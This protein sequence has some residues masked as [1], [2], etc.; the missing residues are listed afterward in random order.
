MSKRPLYDLSGKT[1]R[2]TGAS[3]GIGAH[4]ARRLHAKGVNAHLVGVEPNLLSDL[5]DELGARVAYFDADVTDT[6]DLA[7]TQP[8]AAPRT[9]HPAFATQPVPPTGAVDTVAYGIE[10]QRPWITA[11][12]WIGLALLARDATPREANRHRLRTEEGRALYKR[13]GATVEPGIGN[14]KKIH[15][16]V[17]AA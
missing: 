2:I 4:T 10:Q 9:V 7:F 3:R 13:R 1:V 11:L 8:A 17:A 6:A 5:S 15:R 16:A 14:L 12:R